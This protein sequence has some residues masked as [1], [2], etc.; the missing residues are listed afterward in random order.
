MKS[1]ILDLKNKCS[2]NYNAKSF[3]VQRLDIV[4]MLDY[5]QRLENLITAQNALIDS[6]DLGVKCNN[7]PFIDE[8]IF[9]E[10]KVSDCQFRM[11]NRTMVLN[12]I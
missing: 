1:A 5:I 11:A 8:C 10:G 12:D 4:E 3:L 6:N 7:C 2:L 9:N